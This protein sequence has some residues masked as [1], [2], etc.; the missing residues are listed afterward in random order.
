MG[1]HKALLPYKGNIN[2][3]QQLTGIFLKSGIE[4]IV[5][6]VNQELA[7]LLA[8]NPQSMIQSENVK[9]VVNSHPEHGRFFSLQTGIKHILPEN[10]CLFQNIDNPFTSVKL[11]KNLIKQKTM[12]DVIIPSYLNKSGHP[13]LLSPLVTAAILNQSD[14]EIRIDDFVKK[15]SMLFVETDNRQILTNINLPEDY[16]AAGFLKFQAIDFFCYKL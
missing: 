11:V 8:K 16:I 2:F 4:N 10:Y 3:I 12:A 1:R 7:E 9:I 6:V 5:A 14:S 13:L 15:F